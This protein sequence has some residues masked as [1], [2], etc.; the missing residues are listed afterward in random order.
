ME[1]EKVISYFIVSNLISELI[2]SVLLFFYSLSLRNFFPLYYREVC[3]RLHIFDYEKSFFLIIF[4]LIMHKYS[5]LFTDAKSLFTTSK[6]L[7]MGFKIILE[8]LCEDIDLEAKSAALYLLYGL[9]YHQNIK[10]KARVSK[11]T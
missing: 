10:P 9:Y 3:K 2:H 5:Y 11:N 4:I 8:Y 6:F 7:E 1:S